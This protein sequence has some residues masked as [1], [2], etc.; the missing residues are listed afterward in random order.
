MALSLSMKQD[1]AN[2]K[3]IKQQYGGTSQS[4]PVIFIDTNRKMTVYNEA[5]WCEK[6]LKEK[7]GQYDFS[8]L[9]GLE[10]GEKLF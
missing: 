4:N 2:Y 3:F 6:D 5:Q 9:L 7:W 10:P 8:L 1:M